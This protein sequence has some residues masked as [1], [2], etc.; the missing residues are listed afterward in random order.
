LADALKNPDRRNDITER[1]SR[2]Q[3]AWAW[4]KAK[5]WVDRFGADYDSEGLTSSIKAVDHQIATLTGRLVA[6]RA[7]QSCYEDLHDDYEKQGALQAWQLAVRKMGKTTGT[8]GESYARDARKY[9][10]K[11]RAAI[12]VWIMPLHR[13]A[14]TLEIQAGAFDIV[15]VDEA[16][17]TGPEGLLLQFLGRQCIIVGDDKQIS[18]EAVGVNQHAVRGL[19]EQ[20]LDGFPFAETLNPSSSLFDQA[21]VRYG[22]NRVTLREHF[23][24]MPEIIRFSNDLCYQDTPLVP[25]RQYPAERLEP[26]VVRHVVDGY[27]EGAT[28]AVVNRPEA[29]AVV[30]AIIDC[31]KDPRYTGKSM[32]VICLQGHAQ[33]Q[34]I[35]Q[36]LLEAVGPAPFE[37]RQLI[38]G[39]PYSFQGDERDVIFLSMVAAVDGD[40][41]MAPLV[42]ESFRQRFNV[43]V[44]RAKDQLWLFHSV[45]EDDLHPDC[46]RRR[47][48]EYCYRPATQLLAQDLSV[49]ESEFERAVAKELIHNRCRTTTH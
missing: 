47:L 11:C 29:A 16:S 15:I 27:R 46:M 25:L 32:G 17:Q 49:C 48:L 23:R 42:R 28:D 6:L 20:H 45:N 9:M 41:R 35:E 33:S 3:D 38:C 19:M 13:V 8:H 22:G 1:L 7:W 37:E 26:I 5:Q 24:C 12:P 39:D 10:D 21:L 30:Q 36:M 43:A 34:L 4:R 44:S 31:L 40:R 14:E 18:P 2:V